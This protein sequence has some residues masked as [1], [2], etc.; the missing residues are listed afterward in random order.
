MLPILLL[1]NCTHSSP[2][3]EA[4]ISPSLPAETAK[5]FSLKKP[6][7]KELKRIIPIY[8]MNGCAGCA[9]VYFGSYEPL[10]TR[11]KI[12]DMDDTYGFIPSIVVQKQKPEV[13]FFPEYTNY[14]WVYASELVAKKYYWG[15]L[16]Y[17]VEGNSNEA[18]VI[19]S[20]DEGKTWSKLS[21][22]EKA[23][24]DDHFQSL[25]FNNRGIGF[26]LVSG[27]TGTYKY[28]TADFGRTWSKPEVYESQSEEPRS[29]GCAFS[30]QAPAILSEKCSL[31]KEVLK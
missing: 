13:V 15:V 30:M 9:S 16:D 21:V 4:V 12:H 17:Q 19:W 11:K 2:K 22:I 23:H 28:S 10:R 1:L 6:E 29:S 5:T 3:P 18:I 26:A 31:P 24:F 7:L 25:S 14:G 20:Q 8:A 27:D